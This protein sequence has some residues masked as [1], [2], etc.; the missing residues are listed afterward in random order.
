LKASNDANSASK[1]MAIN[2]AEK[3]INIAE[4]PINATGKPINVSEKPITPTADFTADK[5]AGDYPLTVEFSDQSKN[6]VSYE[7]IFGDGGTSSD[8]NP[9]H[10]YTAEGNYTVTLTVTGTNG[11][12]DASQATISVTGKLQPSAL[13]I[14]DLN[15]TS[16]NGTS[17]TG[18]ATP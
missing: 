12:E 4:K 15:G 16:E 14:D 9:V 6:A 5:T 1:T 11:D 8:K 3:P 2:V 17:V 13:K 18:N 7:W 10:T